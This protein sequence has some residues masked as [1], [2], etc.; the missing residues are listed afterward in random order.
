MTFTE[1]RIRSQD[2]ELYLREYGDPDAPVVVAL[3]GWPDSGRGW[4]KVAPLLAADHRV[5]VPDNRGFGRSERPVG[6]DNYRMT[7][8]IGDVLAIGTWA[9]ADRFFLAGHDFGGAVTWAMC[10]FAPQAVRRAVVLAAP[11]PMR[12]HSAAGDLRQLMRAFYAFLMNTGAPGEALL[13]AQDFG[14]LEHFAFGANPA[15]RPEE[16]AAY[17][18]EWAQPGAITAMSE[19]YRAHYTPDLLNP[20]IPLELP[21][22]PVPVRYLH[23]SKDFAFVPELAESNAEFVDA[24]YDHVLVETSHW[25]LHE[26]PEQVAELIR[27]WFA[28]S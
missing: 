24:D 10:T 25:M 28:R 23:G 13:A 8:L 26:Q 19:W 15:I 17:R 22:A 14:L 5:L 12:M 1:H 18:D 6:T 7:A 2:V 9:G 27:E 16:R 21:K 4:A 11:H 3:H 20:D